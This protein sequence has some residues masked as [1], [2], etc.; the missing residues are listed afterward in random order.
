[1]SNNKKKGFGIEPLYNEKY[2]KTWKKSYEGKIST[3]MHSG[4]IP[5][6]GS[7]YISLS[8]I[9]INSV[10]RSGKHY[11]PQVLLEEG[12]DVVKV[13]KISKHTTDGLEIFYDEENSDKENS[14]AED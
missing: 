12:K 4:N 13:K 6:E 7:Q 8:V 3:K 11:Y 1:M 9:L 5:K 14:K 2:L 10:Y